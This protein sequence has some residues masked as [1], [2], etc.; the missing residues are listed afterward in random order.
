MR[1]IPWQDLCSSLKRSQKDLYPCV[2]AR[3][4]PIRRSLESSQKDLCKQS[5]CAQHRQEQHA[6][7]R[8][9]KS[10][11]GL[12]AGDA[13]KNICETQLMSHY[14]CGS[15][16]QC[17]LQWYC[18]CEKLIPR[19]SAAPAMRHV[20]LQDLKTTTGPETPRFKVVNPQNTA[21]ATKES[22]PFLNLSRHP[23]NDFA[24]RQRHKQFHA[25]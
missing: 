14:S 7:S 13:P 17:E 8:Q 9:R 21:P 24:T 20:S 25:L 10:K 12:R 11:C 16:S 19:Q 6:Q 1:R 18:I 4:D 3:S 5:K 2:C 23:C 15:I 22:P